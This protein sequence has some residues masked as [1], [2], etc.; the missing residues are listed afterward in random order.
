ML[1]FVQHM[2]VLSTRMFDVR[3]ERFGAQVYMCIHAFSGK[4]QAWL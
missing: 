2:Y 1:E 4:M 3:E